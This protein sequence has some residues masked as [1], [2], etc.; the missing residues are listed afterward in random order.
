MAIDTV[1]K[2]RTALNRGL[3]GF[4]FY[5]VPDGAIN[6]LNDRRTAA[7]YYSITSEAMAAAMLNS[8][9][10]TGLSIGF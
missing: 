4:G 6:S 8:H 9:M 10:T 7:T 5:V 1:D 3:R 2:R